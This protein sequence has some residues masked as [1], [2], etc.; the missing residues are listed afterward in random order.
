MKLDQI[1]VCIVWA[2]AVWCLLA[3]DEVSL[4]YQGAWFVAVGM[5]ACHVIEFVTIFMILRKLPPDIAHLIPTLVLGVTYFMPLLN[6]QEKR[7]REGASK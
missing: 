3:L 5:A 2:V 7:K 1:G 6:A 4:A